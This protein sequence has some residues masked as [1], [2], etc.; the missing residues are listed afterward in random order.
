MREEE[1]L[2]SKVVTEN[3]T[4]EEGRGDQT[5]AG[6]IVFHYSKLVNWLVN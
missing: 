4:S 6:R 1:I 2:A 5:S 3:E